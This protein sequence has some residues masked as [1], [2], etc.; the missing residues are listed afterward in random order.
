M[1]SAPRVPARHLPPERVYAD[2][3]AML[4][5]EAALSVAQ[6][7]QFVPIFTPNYLHFP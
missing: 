7:M 6:R 3:Q 4:A 2:Y 1:P 5:A